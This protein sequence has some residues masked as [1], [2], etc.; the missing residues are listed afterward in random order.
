MC[1]LRV[2]HPKLSLSGQSS[3][4]V[5]V[6]GGVV[7][8]VFDVLIGYTNRPNLACAANK[9]SGGRTNSDSGK[10]QNACVETYEK[11]E[12]LLLCPERRCCRCCCQLSAE[13]QHD[14]ES[15]AVQKEHPHRDDHVERLTL[16]LSL[17]LLGGMP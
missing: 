7:V 1:F 3:D 4:V 16:F 14:K 9:V 8:V 12:A 11:D 10:I 15:N 13:E 17:S 5:V 2:N 6:V